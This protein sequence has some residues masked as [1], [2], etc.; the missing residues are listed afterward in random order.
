MIFPQLFPL[1]RFAMLGTLDEEITFRQTI[2]F[3]VPPLLPINS[4]GDSEHKSTDPLGVTKTR[5]QHQ[6]MFGQDPGTAVVAKT[7]IVH[8]ARGAGTVKDFSAFMTVANGAAS[9]V[10]VDIQKSTGGGAFATILTGSE[11]FLASGTPRVIQVFD[12]DPTKVDYVAGDIF[13]AVVTVA[14]GA[15]GQ[16]LG[17]WGTFDELNV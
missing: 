14:G 15:V 9:T 12:L 1:D 13:I 5:H 4:L 6:Q 10:T 8:A 11:V 7:H 17:G 2:Y 16:G 3:S